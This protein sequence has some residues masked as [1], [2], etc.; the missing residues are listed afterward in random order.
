M[1]GSSNATLNQSIDALRRLLEIQ[2]GVNLLA[3]LLI[4]SSMVTDVASLAPIRDPIAAAERNI[5]ANLKA[6]PQTDQTRTIAGL[7]Q[8]LTVVAGKDGIVT[9]R[10]NELNRE[11]DARQVYVA[12][13]AEAARLRTA[14]EG[15]IERQG[16][17][18]QTLS[19]RAISQI[20][21]GRILLIILSIAALAAAG[22]IAWLYVG[23]SIVGR[24]T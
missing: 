6:L 3:G 22:L 23:R 7:Y 9:Q 18:A 19:G 24:L 10:T 5:E 11:Q 13:T 12:A 20:R 4:E 17:F 16:K 14:V 8:K 15:S 21:V 1:P 2:S